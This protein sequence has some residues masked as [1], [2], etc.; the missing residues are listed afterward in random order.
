MDTTE[1]KT[2]TVFNELHFYLGQTA[3][4][5]NVWL[6]DFKWDCG[7]YWGGGYLHTFTNNNNPTASKDIDSHYH[8]DGLGKD[9]NKNL[10]DGF[11]SHIVKTPLTDKE[12]W[13]LCDLMAYF[14]TLRQS[15]E[16]V[17]RGGANYSHVEGMP[18]H[19][20]LGKQLNEIIASEVI[21][22]VTKLLTVEATK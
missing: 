10:Y 1:K 15:A 7:W 18:K 22:Q 2:I 14:Y 17:A 4:G 6:Q 13:H 11:K 12:I 3:D 8:F 9:D 21:P 5:Q 20:D 16:Q 19:K